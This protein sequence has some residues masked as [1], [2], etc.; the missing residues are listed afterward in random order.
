MKLYIFGSVGF[1]ATERPTPLPAHVELDGEAERV[2]LDGS[3]ELAIEGS[4]FTLPPGL[5]QGSHIIC[6]DGAICEPVRVQGNNVRPAGVDL[7]QLL[8]QLQ[9]LFERVRALE[10]AA[11]QKQIN[12]LV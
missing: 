7:R 5:S 9:H 11:G 12:W 10:A 2:L 3:T 4:G 1:F 8:P 6:V